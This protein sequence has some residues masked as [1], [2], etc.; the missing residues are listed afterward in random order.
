MATNI[1]PIPPPTTT[2]PTPTEL[3]STH[4]LRREHAALLSQFRAQKALFDA[5]ASAKREHERAIAE[6]L[7]EVEKRHRQDI[8]VLERRLERSGCGE[9]RIWRVLRGLKE[10][11]GREGE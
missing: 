11:A 2:F 1:P 3:L 6:R 7:E 9:E 8:E 5:E 4:Q 10:R